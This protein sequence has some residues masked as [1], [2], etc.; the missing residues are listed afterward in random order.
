M[1]V[2]FSQ[3]EC[4]AC[5][6][7]G[8]ELPLF[9]DA[10]YQP[11]LCCDICGGK[12][13]GVGAGRLLLYC[14]E[15]ALNRMSGGR[16]W[17]SCSIF[18]GISRHVPVWI[19]G[20]VTTDRVQAGYRTYYVAKAFQHVVVVGCAECF[21]TIII[22]SI[23]CTAQ[24][25]RHHEGISCHA[26][27][28]G[29]LR[30]YSPKGMDFHTISNAFSS[31]HNSDCDHH[32]CHDHP[33]FGYSV[34]YKRCGRFTSSQ[35]IRCPVVHCSCIIDGRSDHTGR[36]PGAKPFLLDRFRTV[37]QHH[38]AFAFASCDYIGQNS[39]CKHIRSAFH[40]QLRCEYIRAPGR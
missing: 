21:L 12:C 17:G 4:F 19:I 29:F 9:F 8:V 35:D 16:L 13:G 33:R 38:V 37:G 7:K 34:D 1:I 32:G 24:A 26:F 3:G 23:Q 30:Q 25:F 22:K 40:Y 6:K 20:I 18:V 15:G 27:T 2:S 39:A 5:F 28:N 36:K 11:W 31:S 14:K 10:G